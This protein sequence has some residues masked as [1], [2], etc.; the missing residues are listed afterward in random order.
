MP[1]LNQKIIEKKEIPKGTLEFGARDESGQRFERFTQRPAGFTPTIPPT[2]G[3]LDIGGV[4]SDLK[5]DEV[6]GEQIVG[7]AGRITDEITGTKNDIEKE[8]TS[9]LG[10]QLT[11]TT[12]VPTLQDALKATKGQLDIS[13]KQQESIDK[14]VAGLAA[15][16]DREIALATRKG[17]VSEAQAGVATGQAGRF[18]SSQLANRF[19]SV[20][21]DIERNIQ[22]LESAKISSLA[23]ARSAAERAARTANKE[24]IAAAKDFIGQAREANDRQQQAIANR[25]SVLTQLS[26]LRSQFE[27]AEEAPLTERE[28]LQNLKLRS[29]IRSSELEAD[30]LQQEL[31]AEVDPT[32][33]AKK[34]AELDLVL[35]KV[36]KLKAETG[37][38][39]KI[40]ELDIVQQKQEIAQSQAN[41]EKTFA[42]IENIGKTDPAQAEI[43]Q[44]KLKGEQLNNRKKQA[45]FDSAQISKG[46]EADV[47][48]EKILNIQSIID[49]VG[50]NSAVGT[51]FL[52]RTAF[53]DK[54]SGQRQDF[55]GSLKNLIDT[56]TLDTLLQLK[57]RGGTLGAIAVK[58]LEIL[59]NSATKISQWEIE[60]SGFYNISEGLFKKELETMK[61]SAERFSKAAREASVGG[62][63]GTPTGGGIGGLEFPE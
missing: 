3:D 59:Q 17:A 49:H 45:A 56:E 51:T 41:L 30:K 10:Q 39:G 20:Q 26:N 37:E 31:D 6:P 19:S 61:T 32:E 23:Q 55:V 18:E 12:D 38:I 53:L 24:D 46:K 11:G 63:S 9:L 27:A 60:D 25:V 36:D 14:Q 58:E 15:D 21:R 16:F 33:K 34:Q 50:L 29:E 40:S 35:G 43:L 8:I 42:E 57:E 5:L 52:G 28:Q 13:T 54:F 44:E 4:G 22:N 2:G 48:D 47:L 1:P 62:V 7:G